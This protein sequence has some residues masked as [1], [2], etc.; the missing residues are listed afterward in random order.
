MNSEFYF[1]VENLVK[2]MYLRSQMDA[3]GWVPLAEVANFNRMKQLS[4]DLRLVG[5]PA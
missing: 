1:S 5:L 2:D 3:E 4:G